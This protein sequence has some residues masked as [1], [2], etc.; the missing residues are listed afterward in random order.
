MPVRNPN[1]YSLQSTRRYPLD[2]NATGTGDGGER[3][4][5][6][7]LV[8]CRLY[9]PAPAGRYAFVSGVSVTSRLVSLVFQAADD[10]DSPATFVPLAAI[11]VPQPAPRDVHIPV[12]ALSPGVGGFVVLGD[13]NEPFSGRFATPRQSLLLPRC[14]RSYNPF[15]IPTLRKRSHASG[16]SGLVRLL[17]EGELEIAGQDLVID[18]TARRAIVL[19]LIQATTGRNVLSTFSGP[20]GGRPESRTCDKEGIET[21]NGVAPDCAGNIDIEFVGL[22]AGPYESC[23]GVTLDFQTG[24]A[25]VC[26]GRAEHLSRTAG[27]FQGRDKCA[28]E[29]AEESESASS[30]S[31][32]SLSS[33]SLSAASLSSEFFEC[34]E[35]PYCDG[36]DDG[37]AE[38]F[39]VENGGFFIETRTE[40]S[41][42]EPCGLSSAGSPIHRVFTASDTSQRNVA[43]FNWCEESSLDRMVTTDIQ[44]AAGTRR[45]GGP[46]LNYRIV[47]PLTNPHIEYH[48]GLLNQNNGR[49]QLLRFTGTGFALVH[50][51]TLSQ[52]AVI[53]DWYRLKMKAVTFGSSVAI[54]LQVLG[55]TN[56][57]WPA[58]QFT[59]VDGNYLPATGAPGLGSDR[60]LARFSFFAV[61]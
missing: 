58:A 43:I 36:F 8:D 7:I 31:A 59:V 3:L 17:G 46:I 42:D 22:T 12:A 5:D 30:I 19:R 24:M 11:S 35:F 53:G 47:E 34:P 13:I 38:F 16:L 23:G 28:E 51:L 33:A 9:F 44:L 50:E 15:P 49:L 41:P 52:P 48:Q 14:A 6:D 54:T 61:D 45:N 55:I 37:S 27:R 18:D 29:L 32:S 20:C 2:D 40:E 56:P 10:I 21:I 26:A 57:A 39:T 60:A 4:P 25:D 1:W